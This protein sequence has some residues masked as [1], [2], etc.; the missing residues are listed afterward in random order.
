MLILIVNTQEV[1]LCGTK[2]EA[3]LLEIES[4]P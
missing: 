2:G 4:E 1:V 3:G